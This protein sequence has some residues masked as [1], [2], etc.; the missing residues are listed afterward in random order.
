VSRPPFIASARTDRTLARRRRRRRRAGALL[1]VLALG[2][3]GVAI[4]ALHPR[5]GSSHHSAATAGGSASSTPA[6]AAPPLSQLGLPLGRPPLTLRLN[7]P[8]AVHLRFRHPPRAG[9]LVNLDTGRVLWRLNP[10][11]RLRIA[12]LTKMMTAL[13]VVKRAPATAH[14]LI[15]PQALA[16]TGSGVGVLPRGKR[17]S[18]EALLGGLLLPSGNDA[19]I[20][21]A[22]HIS[23]TVSR[24]VHLMNVQAARIGMGCTRYSSP[25][26]ILDAGNY[27]C[28]IDLAELAA[29]DIAQPRIAAIARRARWVVPFPIKGGRLFLYNNNP[30]VRLG[31]PGITG[32]KTG[33]TSK[34]GLC[35]VETAERQGVRLAAIVLNSPNA[36]IETRQ[37]LD[38]GFINVYHQQ[39]LPEPLIPPVPVPPSHG[40][41]AGV[42]R[43]G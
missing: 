37:L 21:L 27:S 3:A 38:R 9:L 34:A 20:A 42:V 6:T 10:T 33:F 1:F 2:G 28:A 39:R 8:D 26:G 11:A 41:A 22:Q 32:L 4:A 24:F 30:L 18:L 15:T 17:V 40:P 31:Y 29:A 7:V 16:Y 19:A 5:L 35:L 23:G 25:S 13:L 14:V 36:A 43:R 12:S